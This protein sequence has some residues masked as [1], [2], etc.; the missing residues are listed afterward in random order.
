[1]LTTLAP[2]FVFVGVVNV[3]WELYK[4]HK[5][6]PC[7]MVCTS[8]DLISEYSNGWHIGG[9]RVLEN[10]F[11]TNKSKFWPLAKENGKLHL[12]LVSY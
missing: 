1:M 11:L 7:S 9:L 5:T 12:K 4:Q 3:L 10:V 8:F 6:C 2:G